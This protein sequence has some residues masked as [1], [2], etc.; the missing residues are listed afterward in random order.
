MLYLLLLPGIFACQQ[1]NTPKI[2]NILS[3]VAIDSAKVILYW[4]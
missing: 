4:N 2:A 1:N 3:G